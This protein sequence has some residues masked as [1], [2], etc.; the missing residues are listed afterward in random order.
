MKLLPRLTLSTLILIAILT[1]T[2]HGATIP[3]GGDSWSEYANW[4]DAYNDGWYPECGLTLQI[5]TPQ[6]AGDY[7]VG[8]GSVG[9]QLQS[10]AW[11]KG[12]TYERPEWASG[13]L[14]MD[15]FTAFHFW[16]R[17]TWE[18]AVPLFSV[19]VY[20]EPTEAEVLDGTTAKRLSWQ[21]PTALAWTEFQGAFEDAAWE[22]YSSGFWSPCADADTLTSV[23][24]LEWDY[25]EFFGPGRETRSSSTDCTLWSRGETARFGSRTCS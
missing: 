9:F 5:I 6:T 13:E 12:F 17:T 25:Y 1:A 3:D 21:I 15:G 23:L 16:Y 7:V 14:P 2:A 10:G 24:Q 11:N 19:R 20:V 8:A 4:V 18:T 22:C